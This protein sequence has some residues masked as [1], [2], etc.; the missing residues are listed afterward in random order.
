M[1]KQKP[2]IKRATDFLLN[3]VRP[4]CCD[5]LLPSIR[6]LAKSS[7]VSFVTMWKT[8]K[9]LT[10][11]G[12]IT[13]GPDGNRFALDSERN[14]TVDA[15]VAISESYSFS[16]N[17]IHIGIQQS[18]TD[19][20]YKDIVSGRFT[21]NEKLPSCKEMQLLYGVSFTTLKKSL[22]LLVEEQILEH[23]SNG[24]YIPSLTGSTGH[25]RIV[26]IGCGWESGKI[27]VDYQD[28][29]YFRTVESECIRMNV[30]LDVVVHYRNL[31]RLQFSH[32]ATSKEYDLEDRTILG[33]IFIVANLDS[34][35]E[36]VLERLVRLRR[37]VAVL[38]V[39]GGWNIPQC[40]RGNR[41]VQFFTTTASQLPAKRVAQYL[42][43]KKH[44]KIAFFS[45]F[46]KALWSKRRLIT[47]DEMFSR[48]GFSDGVLKFVH[49]K[50]AYQWDYLN[51]NE[52][53]EDLRG[54]ISEYTQ[55][56]KETRGT[57]FKKFG[58]SGYNIVKYITEWNCASNE[59][60]EK[61]R[62]LF[63]KALDD[64]SISAWVMANDFTATMAIDYL[65]ERSVKIPENLSVISFDNTIDAMEY[66]LT[67]YDFNNSGIISV[68]LR[69]ILAPHTV[70]K[71]RKDGCIEVDGA[72]VVRRSG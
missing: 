16:E 29:N 65:K 42:L 2:G 8:V 67:S 52:Q 15:D 26:A 69:F 13:N 64:K 47:L 11:S 28:K 41:H 23:R 61:M 48:A 31:G 30:Q 27:W 62:P 9:L 72:L 4:K 6:M 55:W 1:E 71:G 5:G 46:H 37:N 57:V 20:L 44:Q 21:T 19:K 45:P 54:L 34:N 25:A 43:S 59:I 56:K 7:G 17:E 70:K 58:N 53:N 38:D 3:I 40:A 22:S 24:Y 51:K 18:I 50:F 36:E 35:P 32:S 68:I 14:R 63:E 10:E 12:Q 49:D 33:Y 39:V 66:Q 60:Y